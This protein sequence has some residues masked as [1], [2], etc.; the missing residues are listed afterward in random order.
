MNVASQ[1]VVD[2]RMI[3]M[4]AKKKSVEDGELY[5]K[6]AIARYNPEVAEIARSGLK[7]M[8]KRYPG[9]R[10]LVYDRR[11]SLPFGF[12]PAEGGA[13]FSIVLYPRWARFF[14]LEGVVIEDPEKRLE[15]A[16]SQVRSIRLDEGAAVLDDPYIRGLMAQALKVAGADLKRGSGEVVLKSVI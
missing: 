2:S 16:G 12:A 14:F 1:A 9:A 13:I 5:L 15:G 7:K 4:T 10:V 11:Q 3:A 6:N 8:R